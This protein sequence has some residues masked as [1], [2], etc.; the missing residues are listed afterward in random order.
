LPLKHLPLA[1]LDL[2]AN[3]ILHRDISNGNILLSK[4]LANPHFFASASERLTAELQQVHPERKAI[5]LQRTIQSDL[6][7]L[8]HDFDMAGVRRDVPL[9]MQEEELFDYLG[10]QEDRQ[11]TVLNKSALTVCISRSRFPELT[12]LG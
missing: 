11:P 7:G 8:L 10:G 4:E 3:G 2:S 12:Y 1:I 9:D 6:G 5:F